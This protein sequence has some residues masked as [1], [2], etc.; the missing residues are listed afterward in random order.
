MT[1]P[2]ECAAAAIAHWESGDLVKN[3]RDALLALAGLTPRQ[4]SALWN[5]PAYDDLYVILWGLMPEWAQ[6]ASYA[7]WYSGD[8]YL[9]KSEVPPLKECRLDTPLRDI[10][11]YS[12]HYHRRM[13]TKSRHYKIS[14]LFCTFRNWVS[15]QL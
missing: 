13:F 6:A 7:D 5:Q 3:H 10:T 9:K 15:E 8:K 11:Y 14:R 4:I 2:E 1:T 12:D